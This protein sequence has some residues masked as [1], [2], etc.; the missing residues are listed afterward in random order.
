M[1][2]FIPFTI[3]VLA[4]IAFVCSVQYDPFFWDTVQLASKHAHFFYENSLAWAPLPAEVDSGHPPFLGYYLAVVWTFFGKTLPASHWAMLPFLLANLW[5]IYRLGLRLGGPRWAWWLVPLALLDPVLAGQSALVSPDVVLTTWFLLAVEGILG[6]NRWFVAVAIAG[7]CTVSTRGMMTAAALGVW[8]LII[9]LPN[10]NACRVA[11]LRCC[12]LMALHFLPFLPG[13]LLG[14]GFLWWHWH[15]T[16]WLGYHPGS[17]WAGAFERA[18]GWSVLRNAAVLCWRWSDAGRWA[19]WAVLCW[20]W[21]SK[22]APSA[23]PHLAAAERDSRVLRLLLFL[24]LFLAP[25]AL[26]YANLSAHRYFLPLFLALHLLVF[27]RVVSLPATPNKGLLNFL[28]RPAVLLSLLIASLATGNL[29][30]YPRGVSMNWD[31]TLAHLPYH[32]MREEA[33]AYLEEQN[34]DFL[35]VGTAFPS[36]NT[37]ENLQLNGDQ[38]CFSALDFEKNQFVLASNIFNDLNEPDYLKLERE[39]NLQK[40]WQHP[41]GVWMVLYQRKPVE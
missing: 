8:S 10:F 37:G 15:V 38:R 30:V 11:L 33:V 25:S 32:A 39:W 36:L 27:Q 9:I 16:G 40:K 23:T 22:A 17:P 21:W 20:L 41:A 31:S 14:A 6:K 19:E 3:C 34:I 1:L 26:L 4:V 7:L 28:K 29:W 35:T 2:R 13:L 18:E 12:R 24:L 5:L